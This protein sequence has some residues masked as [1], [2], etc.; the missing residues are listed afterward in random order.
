M[1][2]QDQLCG[3]ISNK[4]KTR[5]R[6]SNEPSAREIDPHIVYEASTGNVLVNCFQTGGYSKSGKLPNWR[7]Q[8]VADITSVE[9]LEEC[10]SV[11]KDFNPSNKEMYVRTICKVA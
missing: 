1:S 6:V 7:Y 11:H 2:I 10:F 8:V 4:R 9:I 3:A 5:I